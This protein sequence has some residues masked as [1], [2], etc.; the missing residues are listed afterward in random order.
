MAAHPSTSSSAMEEA[1]RVKRGDVCVCALWPP[2]CSYITAPNIFHSQASTTWGG[3][4]RG[5]RKKKKERKLDRGPSGS[6]GGEALIKSSEEEKK[7]K[8]IKKKGK[9]AAAEMKR[10]RLE[11]TRNVGCE[12]A[13]LLR[14]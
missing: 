3:V 6:V 7:V 1:P 12:L 5:G 2:G 9:R 8:R 13:W 11:K 4:E 14:K 10:N